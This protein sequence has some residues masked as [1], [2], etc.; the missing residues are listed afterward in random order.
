MICRRTLVLASAMQWKLFNGNPALCQPVYAWALFNLAPTT[1]LDQFRL[2]PGTYNFWFAVDYPMDGT[3]DL[4]G[5]ILL[6]NVTVI[7]P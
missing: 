5:T 7:V 1:V 2:S 3:L 4:N 6:N